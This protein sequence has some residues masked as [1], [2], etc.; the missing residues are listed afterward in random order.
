M[1][2]MNK[3]NLTEIPCECGSM[4]A[5]WYGERT[6]RREYMCDNCY[7]IKTAIG[8]LRSDHV[9]ANKFRLGTLGVQDIDMALAALT[10]ME[11][12]P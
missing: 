7:R 5:R 11:A 2:A 10:D 8:H 6:G 9:Q 4:N 3:N 12:R 1:C